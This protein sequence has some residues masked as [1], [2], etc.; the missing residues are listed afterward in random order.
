MRPSP[1]QN[2]TSA[3]LPDLGPSGS[4][5]LGATR[6]R[7]DPPGIGVGIAR[8]PS[9][10]CGFLD[11]A[12]AACRR[13]LSGTR[14]GAACLRLRRAGVL[15]RDAA[16]ALQPR[17]RAAA[18]RREQGRHDPAA[19]R[20]LRQMDGGLR[21]ADRLR[22]RDH[23]RALDAH[24]RPG[25]PRERHRLA[26]AGRRR[27]GG[28][29]RLD[30]HRCLRRQRDRRGR[31]RHQPDDR[32]HAADPGVDRHARMGTR[33]RTRT[34]G[35]AG[36]ADVGTAGRRLLER[37]GPH[38]GRRSGLPLPLRSPG[39]CARGFP[40]LAADQDRLR[41]DA[42]RARGRRRAGST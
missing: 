17:R 9:H 19:G 2:D 10:R 32:D 40:V 5:R 33:D 21:C 3:R 36:H 24:E 28:H 6:S 14:D 29:A 8:E 25:R 20:C 37:P 34:L 35:H 12:S 42:G 18:A 23:R 22:R 13:R 38:A 11:A 30:R 27:H 26:G 31:H 15:V 1:P 16:L 7:R 4:V 39:R 41:R